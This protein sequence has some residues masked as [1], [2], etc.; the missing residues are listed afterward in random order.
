MTHPVKSGKAARCLQDK[1][2]LYWLWMGVMCAGVPTFKCMGTHMCA[3]V[4]IRRPEVGIGCLLN[5]P[6]PYTLRQ[7]L[8]NPE[9]QAPHLNLELA[10]SVCLARQLASGIP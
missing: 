1:L 2:Y 10:D 5:Y 6:P 8:L 7:C 9:L 4:F 3:C